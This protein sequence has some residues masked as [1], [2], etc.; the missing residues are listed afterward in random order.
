MDSYTKNINKK[1]IVTNRCMSFHVLFPRKLIVFFFYAYFIL[2]TAAP[3]WR[4]EV[5]SY[6]MSRE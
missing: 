6:T 4:S 1:K 3:V 5:V 2:K